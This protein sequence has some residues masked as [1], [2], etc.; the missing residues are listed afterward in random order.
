MRKPTVGEVLFIV[1]RS[2][3]KDTSE[4]YPATVTK[5]GKKYF[6]VAF[7][8]E[9]AQFS[10]DTWNEKT[11]YSSKL[12]LYESKEEYDNKLRKDFLCALI[13]GEVHR[14]TRKLSVEQL[15][16]IVD[17]AELEEE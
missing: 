4:C 16:Q 8:S 9:N 6:R 5:V 13:S 10:V 12:S 1:I 11:R 14:W 3:W 17:I 2:M 7:A 15:Q